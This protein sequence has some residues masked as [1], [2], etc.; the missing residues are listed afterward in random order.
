MELTSG[1]ALKGRH[2]KAMGLDPS[3][4]QSWVFQ[5]LKGRNSGLNNDLI[6]DEKQRE[7][8]F[9]LSGLGSRE[10]PTND[11]SRP[12]ALLFRPAGAVPM[13]QAYSN[14]NDSGHSVG[15]RVRA[16][17]VFV[18]KIDNGSFVNQL[19]GQHT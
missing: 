11:G 10:G 6:L 16:A 13:R 8:Y 19:I 4:E 14:V 7:N 5:A 9:A 17:Y 2:S 3:T 12:I 1:I 15:Q 18:K